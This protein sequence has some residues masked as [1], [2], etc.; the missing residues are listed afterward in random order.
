MLSAEVQFL[1]RGR[2]SRTKAQPGLGPRQRHS[3]VEWED[4][5]IGTVEAKRVWILLYIKGM[6]LMGTAVRDYVNLSVG[7]GEDEP[8]VRGYPKMA[9]RVGGGNLQTR[10]LVPEGSVEHRDACLFHA[11]QHWLKFWPCKRADSLAPFFRSNAC[12]LSLFFFFFFCQVSLGTTFCL[13]D[14][15]EQAV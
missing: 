3:W 2:C 10:K 1:C 9:L 12:C 13:W 11:G 6:F 14:L 7:L 15:C 5:L 4:R 8:D